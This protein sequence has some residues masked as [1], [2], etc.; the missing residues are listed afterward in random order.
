MVDRLDELKVLVLSLQGKS[1]IVEPF[2][3]RLIEGVT[4]L[5][6]LRGVDV[7]VH[8]AGHEHLAGG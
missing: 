1:V 8:K 5:G 2:V 7:Q 6:P 3:E 4:S